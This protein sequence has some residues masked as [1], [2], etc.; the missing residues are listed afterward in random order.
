MAHGNTR[1]PHLSSAS[2]R[3]LVHWALGLPLLAAILALA[4][5]LLLPV[6]QTETSFTRSAPAATNLQAPG[7]PKGPRPFDVD[8]RR[9]GGGQR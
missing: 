8:I 2:L 4:V 5:A 3:D 1:L 6:L 7:Q 9:S